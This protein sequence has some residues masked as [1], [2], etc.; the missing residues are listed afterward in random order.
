MPYAIEGTSKKLIEG[1]ISLISAVMDMTKQHAIFFNSANSGQ[2][3][4]QRPH[5]AFTIDCGLACSVYVKLQDDLTS[6]LLLCMPLTLIRESTEYTFKYTCTTCT[7][8]II[9]SHTIL[10]FTLAWHILQCFLLL[11]FGIN[12]ADSID[13]SIR[14]ALLYVPFFRIMWKEKLT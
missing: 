7:I 1:T 14:L 12:I 13:A 10:H 9:V 2:L 6:S 4:I 5:V 3:K 11:K 8:G